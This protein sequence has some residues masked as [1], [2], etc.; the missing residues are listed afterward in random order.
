MERLAKIETRYLILWLSKL[1]FPSRNGTYQSGPRQSPS[2]HGRPT[3]EASLRKTRLWNFIFQQKPWSYK[4]SFTITAVL[5]PKLEVSGK[6]CWI[7]DFTE[8]VWSKIVKYVFPLSKFNEL[9]FCLILL[10]I[11]ASQGVL[12][13]DPVVWLA[14]AST[15]QDKTCCLC[16]AKHFAKVNTSNGFYF[17]K[18]QTS[19][20]FALA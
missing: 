12:N 15:K 18:N 14:G 2:C 13:K 10:S 8:C 17:Q 11:F 19:V 4:V 7:F 3:F 6:F 16:L 5:L 1:R 20:L 9:T